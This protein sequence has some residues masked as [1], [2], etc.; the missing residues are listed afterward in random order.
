LKYLEAHGSFPSIVYRVFDN[1]NHAKQFLSGQ[2]RLSNV[3][4]YRSTEDLKRQDK[5]EGSSLFI[6]NNICH[7]SSFS[8]NSVFVYCFH[9]TLRAAK[10]SKFGQYIIEINNPKQLAI[11]ITNLFSNQNIKYYGGIEGVNIEYTTG[12]NRIDKLSSIERTSLIYSQ[13]P[14]SYSEEEEFRFVLISEKSLK[15]HNCIYLDSNLI[16][17]KLL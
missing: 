4:I 9:R 6:H 13:K 14:I 15:A 10:N 11:S 7:H 1:I 16:D 17:A 12:G 2:I 3:N 5:D 8:S